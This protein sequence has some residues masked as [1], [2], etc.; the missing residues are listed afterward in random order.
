MISMRIDQVLIGQMLNDQQVGLY[1]AGTRIAEIWYFIPFGIASSVFPMFVK[2][3]KQ[4][5]ALYYQRIQ[6]YYDA[7]AALSI[8]VSVIVTVLSGPIIRLLYGSAYIGSVVALRILIWC[9]V[10]MAIGAPWT[11]RMLVEN[12]TKTMFHF[13][14][15]GAALNLVLNLLLIPR[16]GIE[17]SAIA[18]LIS[19][20]A[21]IYVLCP[22]MKSQ[23]MAFVMIVKAVFLVWLF[24]WPQKAIDT[25]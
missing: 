20:G 7:S 15:F 16:F 25:D 14:L 23:R 9:G 12:R 6:K 18:S 22:F 3:K 1:S 21:W 11:T 10:P 2:L 8:A 5:E 4:N 19:Y 13:Q 24:N 17:G